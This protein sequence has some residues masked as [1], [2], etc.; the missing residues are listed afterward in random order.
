MF[1][2]TDEIED[3]TR[4]VLE[5]NR[6]AKKVR[7]PDTLSELADFRPAWNQSHGHGRF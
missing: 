2:D 7:V 5:Y 1:S 4:F 3:R 6:L